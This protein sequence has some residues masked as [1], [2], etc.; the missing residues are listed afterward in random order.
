MKTRIKYAALVAA[1]L[2]CCLASSQEHKPVYLFKG[3]VK[4]NPGV[5]IDRKDLAVMPPPGKFFTQSW[6]FVYYTDDGGGGYIQFSILQLYTLKQIGVH[7]T[8]YT[9][10]GKMVYRKEILSPK[11][12]KW[13][14]KEPRLMF[15]SSSWSGYYPEFRLTVPLPDLE[16]YLTFNCLTPPW[17]PGQG[18]VHFGTPQGDWYDL[19]VFIPLA[20][21]S[22]TIRVDN[23][24]RKVL[25]WGYADHNT[26]TV[27]FNTMVEH[28]YALRSFSEHWAVQFLDYHS[29]AEFGRQRIS[30]LFAVK[31]GRMV[32][33]TDRFELEASDWTK[34]PRRGREYPRQVKLSV[35]DPEFKLEAQIK[36]TRLL[37]VLDVRDQVPGWL[38]PVVSRLIKQ[39]AFIRQK[40]EF[41]WRINYQGREETVPVQGIL[42]YTIVEKE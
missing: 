9:P 37:D 28:L 19:I 27:W 39:P 20:R 32:Y 36:G 13:D 24:E 15:G 6:T 22:G 3:G 8:H 40:A 29:P 16:T 17:R 5:A 42:E 34:E 30:W 21:I 38:E 7:H 41:S 35:N 31:D 12:M 25:G 10:E 26:Q 11:D 2:F 23:K 1:F 14:E 33:A 18:P 4:I